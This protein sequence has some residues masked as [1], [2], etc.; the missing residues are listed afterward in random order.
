[1][2][3]KLLVLSKI[4]NTIIITKQLYKTLYVDKIYYKA[5]YNL[6]CQEITRIYAACQVQSHQKM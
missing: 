2:T 1:M 5:R 6:H 4:S 3:S